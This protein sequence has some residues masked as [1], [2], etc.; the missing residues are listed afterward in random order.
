MGLQQNVTSNIF[1]QN[2]G[3]VE[4]QRVL[5]SDAQREVLSVRCKFIFYVWASC[6]LAF[7]GVV[8]T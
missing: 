6:G 1:N 7:L 3:E 5:I 8:L 4:A 2:S